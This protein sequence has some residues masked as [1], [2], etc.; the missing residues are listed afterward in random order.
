MRSPGAGAALFDELVVDLLFDEYSR[1][2]A[3][4]LALIEKQAEVSALYRFIQV[5]VRE[6]DVRALA[7]QFQSDAL[8]IGFRGSFHDRM[9]DLGGAGE[10]HLVH[11][12]MARD[13]GAG[14][15]AESRQ[16]VDHAFWES[17]FHDQLANAQRG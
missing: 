15:G 2:G 17:R 7:A 8:Q 1:S 4:A 13:G 10:C 5:G 3:A 16:Q 12:H 9:P 6:D 11:V 14:R